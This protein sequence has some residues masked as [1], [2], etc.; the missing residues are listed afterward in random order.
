MAS[1]HLGWSLLTSVEVAEDVVEAGGLTHLVVALGEVGGVA[2]RLGV[3]PGGELE[4]AVALLEVGGHRIA[5]RAIMRPDFAEGVRE[6]MVEYGL[7]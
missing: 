3:E 1:A 4:I 2:G 7:D 5:A 6:L